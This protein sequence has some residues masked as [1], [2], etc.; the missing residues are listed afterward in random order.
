[1]FKSKKADTTMTI[2]GMSGS[3]KTCYLLGMFYKMSGGLKGYNLHTDDDT[4]TELSKRYDILNDAKQG[5]VRFPKPTDVPE[6]FLFDLQYGYE[7]ILSFEWADYPGGYLKEKNDGDVEGYTEIKNSILNSSTLFIC[8]DG[9]LLY[10]DDTE[11]KTE[12]VR[13]NCSNA[14]NHFFSEYRKENN[15]LPPTAF[16]VTKYDECK[17]DTDLNELCE[18]VQDAFSGFFTSLPKS[19]S[20]TTIIPVSLGTSI[21]EDDYTGNLKPENIHLPIFMGIWFSLRDYVSKLASENSELNEKLDDLMQSVS[22]ASTK[23]RD[24]VIKL[25]QEISNLNASIKQEEGRLFGGNKKYLLHLREKISSLMKEIDI[26]NKESDNK[27]N[28]AGLCRAKMIT[29]ME[30][31]LLRLN[32]ALEKSDKL[33]QE[34]D[35]KLPVVYLNDEKTTFSIISEL[36][37]KGE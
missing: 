17:N 7:D 32:I 31:N 16:I 26:I 19:R 24:K 9:S 29:E 34:L 23:N 4:H 25:Q 1:M 33:F 13:D 11:E 3:G 35:K 14:I 22:L 36:L 5:K 30:T 28:D 8:I 10:G 18:I 20:I 21:A 2:L 37:D 12:R 27:N 15:H 6:K